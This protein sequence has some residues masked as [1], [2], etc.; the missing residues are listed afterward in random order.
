V[1]LQV[2]EPSPS[3]IDIVG[4]IK[5]QIQKLPDQIVS[6][7]ILAS[8]HTGAPNLTTSESKAIFLLRHIL[9]DVEDLE[10]LLQ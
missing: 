1:T 8:T 9:E 5:Q 6:R 4:Q 7:R 3:P 10:R 2:M